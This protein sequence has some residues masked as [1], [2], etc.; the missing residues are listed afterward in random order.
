MMNILYFF[1]F[2]ISIINNTKKNQ[3]RNNQLKIGARRGLAKIKI[4]LFQSI[5]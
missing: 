5:K 2:N 3:S 4:I 1:M